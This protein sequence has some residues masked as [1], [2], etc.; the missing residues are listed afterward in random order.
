MIQSIEEFLPFRS[1][2]IEIFL[3]LAQYRNT[4]ETPRQLHRF[5]EGLIP[6]MHRPEHVMSHREDAFDNFR[7]IIHEL[8]LYATASFLKYGCFEAVS[9]MLR[10]RYYWKGSQLPD[11]M[12][13][14]SEMH[15]TMKS[16][17]YRNQRLE[18][19]RLSLRA[20]LLEQRAKTS[21]IA[22]SEIMQADFV[23]YMR[24]CFDTLRYQTDRRW[25]GQSWWPVTLLYVG[26]HRDAFE[27]FAR[28]E[29]RE[30]FNRIKCLFDIENKDEFLPVFQA[31][32]DK[33]LYVPTGDILNSVN[34]V[35]LLGYDQLA[36]RP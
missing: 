17:E 8:F 23:L 34:P 32:K 33:Q 4:P 31:Y 24:D 6:Y 1:E 2:A 13:A 18:L 27:I 9:Y 21:G 20:D 22:F 5:F 14:F 29:S 26:R 10:Y 12:L 11:K 7:F 15:E 25:F 30:Y 19:R 36:T 35:V 16:L 3:A 28:A